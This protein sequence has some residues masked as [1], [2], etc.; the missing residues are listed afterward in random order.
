ML[1]SAIY[2]NACF[3]TSICDVCCDVGILPRRTHTHVAGSSSG[4]N[5]EWNI[6][7]ESRSSDCP[8]KFFENNGIKKLRKI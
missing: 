8:N 4:G 2:S 3:M 1:T 5:L 7:R 6:Y